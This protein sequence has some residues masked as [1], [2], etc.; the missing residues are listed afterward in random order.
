MHVVGRL[1]RDDIKQP[2]VWLP[3]ETARIDD[4]QIT[5]GSGNAADIEAVATPRVKY[6][7][8]HRVTPINPRNVSE[9]Q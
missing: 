9:T 5:L 1:P 8:A 7:Q 6:H 4:N 2:S 3:V